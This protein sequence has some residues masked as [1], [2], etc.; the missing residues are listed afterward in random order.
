MTSN[1]PDFEAKAVDMIGLYLN[2]LAHV[3]V[4]CVRE[5][6]AIQ[7]LDRKDPVLPLLCGARRTARF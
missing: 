3:A 6:A 2:P 4:F 1:E 7:T 5:K